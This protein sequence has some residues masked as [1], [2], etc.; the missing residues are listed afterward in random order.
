MKLILIAVCYLVMPAIPFAVGDT[1][2]S[3]AAINSYADVTDR[4]FSRGTT[5][6]KRVLTGTDGGGELRAFLPN[7][8]LTKLVFTIGLSNRSLETHFY[9]RDDELVLIVEREAFFK[10]DERKGERDPAQFDGKRE[11]RYYIT[12]GNLLWVS[13]HSDAAAFGRED[14]NESTLKSLKGLAAKLAEASSSSEKEV[15]LE[16]YLKSG[17]D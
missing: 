4:N 5:T 16:T 6:V 13:R 2:S 1:P 9:F 11:E 12:R 17:G 7:N 8:R 15:D 3:V 10:F 14:K